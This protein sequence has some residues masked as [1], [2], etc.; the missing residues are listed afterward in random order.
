[1]NDD[2][3]N[4][5]LAAAGERWR[6]QQEVPLTLDPGVLRKGRRPI[7]EY[8]ASAGGLL[9]ALAAILVLALSAPSLGPHTGDVPQSASPSD[10]ALTSSVP[11]A[12]QAGGQ[13]GATDTLVATA[14]AAAAESD[15]VKPGDLVSATGIVK[16]P[17]GGEF[18]ICPPDPSILMP[19]E[20]GPPACG[21]LS[22]AVTGIAAND[23]PGWTLIAGAGQSS[24]V[25]VSGVWRNG[26]I[27]V[28]NVKPAGLPIFTPNELPS[29]C[30][31][32]GTSWPG[33][34][35]PGVEGEAA[36]ANLAELIAQHSDQFAPY[37]RAPLDG[38]SSASALVTIVGTL[39]DSRE[40]A[41]MIA[42]SFQYNLCVISV[43]YSTTELDMIEG[44]VASKDS[45][46]L[47]TVDAASDRV[48]ITLPF[49][50]EE[51]L[52]LIGADLPAVGFD[53]LMVRAR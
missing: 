20:P 10:V 39:G 14:T 9:V 40:A 3:I 21:P 37:W 53:P 32:S 17:P 4:M 42:S 31:P 52:A 12:S 47:T 48:T 43:P 8:A 51:V 46:W 44:R 36:L 13:G 50:D 45:G 38:T 2:D 35:P 19:G 25:I 33:D 34:V 23:L 22:V 16:G 29:S 18:R 1:M 6:E 41:G 26:A 11:I 27:S 7:R 15:A 24:R 5:I 49:V 30:T 28:D